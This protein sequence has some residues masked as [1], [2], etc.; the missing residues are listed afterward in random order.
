MKDL[1][2]RHNLGLWVGPA[3]KVNPAGH[4]F[5]IFCSRQR[6]ATQTQDIMPVLMLKDELYSIVTG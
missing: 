2:T 3:L 1:G 5:A 4:P 6:I